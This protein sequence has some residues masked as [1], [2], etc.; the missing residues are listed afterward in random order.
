MVSSSWS[1]W[2]KWP[3]HPM[4][5]LNQKSK[6]NV[7]CN[8]AAVLHTHPFLT[9][10]SAINCRLTSDRQTEI[11]RT[12]VNKPNNL[13]TATNSMLNDVSE[14]VFR[15]IIWVLKLLEDGSANGYI[16][17][18]WRCYYPLSLAITICQVAVPPLLHYASLSLPVLVKSLQW[19]LRLG[20]RGWLIGLDTRALLPPL[21]PTAQHHA[22]GE[23]MEE[24]Q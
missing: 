16:R 19:H 13:T 18:S 3:R 24:W 8:P 23:S 17:S 15:E 10:S 7:Q 1:V 2:Q 5:I 11:P 22:A 9:L 14:R 4:R 21:L 20:W 12:W 6:D